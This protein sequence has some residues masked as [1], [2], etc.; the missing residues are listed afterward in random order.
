MV[1]LLPPYHGATIRCSEGQIHEFFDRLSSAVDIPIMIK[2]AP[3]S[4]AN[5]TALLLARM[6]REIEHVS[7]FK[8]EMPGKADKLRELITLRADALAD[9]GERDKGINRESDIE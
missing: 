6:A 9:P 8:I 2:D 5:L 1:M 7:Y 4:G 3:M